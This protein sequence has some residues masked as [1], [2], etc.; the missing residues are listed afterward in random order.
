MVYVP[1][2]E[3]LKTADIIK[4]IVSEMEFEVKEDLF[5]TSDPDTDVTNEEGEK[6]IDL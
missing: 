4:D 6:K 2:K 3:K 5:D 1:S